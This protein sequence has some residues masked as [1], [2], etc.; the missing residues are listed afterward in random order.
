[1][2]QRFGHVRW[3]FAGN[4][5]GGAVDARI[6]IA[7]GGTTSVFSIG[8]MFAGC[9]NAAAA[10]AAATM[11]LRLVVVAAA[12]GSFTFATATIRGRTLVTES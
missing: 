1:M 12:V 11:R 2:I 9:I 5:H 7:A 8:T 6:V 10:A 3:H 4:Q